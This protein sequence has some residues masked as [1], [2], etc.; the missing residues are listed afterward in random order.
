[1]RL[2]KQVFTFILRFCLTKI[3]DIVCYVG[4]KTCAKTQHS[5]IGVDFQTRLSPRVPVSGE[6]ETT[7][8]FEQSNIHFQHFNF[9]G[10]LQV[11][12]HQKKLVCGQSKTRFAKNKVLR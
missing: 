10:F 11:G 9:D 1:M 6:T 5:A 4:E 8:F 7:S 3:K 12:K 2:F